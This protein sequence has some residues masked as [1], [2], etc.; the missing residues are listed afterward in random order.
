MSST[1]PISTPAADE[2]ALATFK[3]TLSDPFT[4]AVLGSMGPET[5]ERARVVLTSLI[6]HLHAFAR[7]VELT[8]PEWM[9]GVTTMN[10][11]GQM[12]NEQR[13]E[14]I[15]ITD[16]LGLESLVDQIT[17]ETMLHSGAS[18]ITLS[19]ILGPF[20]RENAPKYENGTDI[21]LKHM[22]GED[23][24]FI[25]GQVLDANTGL[26]LVGAEVDVWHTAPNGLYE[27]QDPDQPDWNLRGVFTTDS[28]GRY[29]MYAL[30]PTS[31]PIP[32]DGPAGDILKLMGRHP[33]RPGHIHLIVRKEGYQP[34]TTQL[35]DRRDKYV[36]NDAVFAVKD[37]LIVDFVES[38]KEKA[39]YE[40]TYDIR[41]SKTKA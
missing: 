22:E 1:T 30:R 36:T 23:T 35:Y 6:R 7:E 24:A 25:Q 8:T 13:N 5:P 37:S 15:L 16:V 10:R 4:N 28:E 40:L 20:Y 18:D 26:P 17:Q 9:L 38:K 12:T 33:M 41:L 14:G 32:F 29:S 21:V 27:Q 34:L 19:A 2:H 11:G 31:Y 39:A 3:A